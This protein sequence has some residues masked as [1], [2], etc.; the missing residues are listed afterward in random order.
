MGN[1]PV[2]HLHKNKVLKFAETLIYQKTDTYCSGLQRQILIAALQEERKT[3]DQLAEEC[4]YSPKYV[5]Q[6]VAPKLWQLLSQVLNTKVTK[7]TVCGVLEHALE[8]AEWQ[9]VNEGNSGRLEDEMPTDIAE[10]TADEA[11]V[12]EIA[13]QK[14]TILLVDDQPQNLRLLSELLEE[15]GYEVQQAISGTV[16]LQALISNRTFGR[17]FSQNLVST[18]QP[19]LILLDIDM[20]EVDGYSV[21]QQIKSTSETKDI[22]VIFISA[23]N[24]AWDK[25]RAFSVGGSDYISKPFK[26]VEV[27]ARVE[28]QLK[29]KH[30]QT[31]LKRKN[32]QLKQAIRELQR[33]AAIDRLTQVANRRRFDEY[34]L[35]C[36][37][38]AIESSTQI[39]LMFIQ[40]NHFDLYTQEDT[41][42]NTQEAHTN[43][44]EALPKEDR[45]L[46]QLAQLIQSTVLAPQSLTCRYGTLTFA[47]CLPQQSVENHPA[48][49]PTEMAELLLQKIQQVK[50][51]STQPITVNVGLAIAQPT[52]E[53]T[54]ET[55]LETADQALQQAKQQQQNS[56]V[57]LSL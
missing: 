19:D 18:Q 21:C 28:N 17:T 1:S 34:L 55:L 56:T 23:L 20:P 27:L 25:V 5:K 39:T 49:Q 30:L 15:Q 22:P 40:L 42:G 47:I 33:L 44:D 8:Q 53:T 10:F 13:V 57:A 46:Q 12:A 48:A 11:A 24:E 36:W 54:L 37:K 52:L 26:I 3:Y 4:G 45:I 50:M 9:A 32:Q 38:R 2:S 43:D 7:A 16:A 31:S 6:D 41:Q 51:P 35:A 29:I 14:G